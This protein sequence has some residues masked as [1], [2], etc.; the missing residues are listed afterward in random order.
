[1]VFIFPM[2]HTHKTDIFFILSRLEFSYRAR[3]LI[4]LSL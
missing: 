3:L 1:M 2:G 4:I